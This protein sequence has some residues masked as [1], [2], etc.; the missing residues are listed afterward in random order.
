MNVSELY[1]CLKSKENYCF[2]YESIELQY[3]NITIQ[4]DRPTIPKVIDVIRRK[5]HI[6]NFEN[7]QI[8]I[9][10][11]VIQLIE[12]VSIVVENKYVLT[13]TTCTM[14]NTSEKI[15]IQQ[16]SK[17]CKTMEDVKKYVFDVFDEYF[18]LADDFDENYND[19]IKQFPTYPDTNP[20]QLV[21]YDV[22]CNKLIFPKISDYYSEY[23]RNVCDLEGS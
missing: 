14:N 4:I 15:G 21:V 10:A 18:E 12:R 16:N 3:K 1:N 17:I 13:I 8:A 6:Y 23:V 5:F 7:F 2:P 11:H 19:F 22:N 20:I 9:D